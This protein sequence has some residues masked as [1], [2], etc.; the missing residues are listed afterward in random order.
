MSKKILGLDLGTNSIGWA[1]VDATFKIEN[2][3]QIVTSYNYIDDCGVRIFP[4]GVNDIGKGES[5]K[6]NNA[7]RT[8]NRQKRRHFYRKRLRKIKLLKVLI[9]QGMCPLKLEELNSWKNWDRV[10][11]SE[12]KKFPESPEFV[13]WIQ[14][15]PYKLRSKAIRGHLSL[16]ELG[17]VFYHLIQ[18]R[19][20]LSSRKGNDDP[21]TLYEKGKPEENILPINATKDKIKDSSL[22]YYLNSIVPQEGMPYK[23]IT[24]EEGNLIRAR[25]RYTTRDMYIAEFEVIW[26]KQAIHLGL[27]NRIAEVKRTRE[28]K[29]A[30]TS[31]RNQSRIEHLINIYGKDNV[32]IQPQKKGKTRV[33]TQ[34]SI[35]LKKYL[36]GNIVEVVME[37]GEK[38]LRFNSNE[39]VLFWQRPLRSQKSLI[40]NCRFENK[41][42]VINEEDS[43]VYDDKG[44]QQF[45][46]KKPCPVSHP[47]FEL[48]RAFQFINNIRYG[49]NL[50]LTIEQKQQVL[51]L[52][53]KN[54]KNFNFSDIPKLLKLTY[55][56]FNYEDDFKVPGNTTIK[57]IKSLFK[58]DVWDKHMVDIWHCFYFYDDNEKLYG[59]LKQDYGYLE[60]LETI[61]KIKLKEGYGNVSLKAIRNIQYFLEKGFQYDRAVILGGIR[62]AFG[63]R[64]SHFEES[65]NELIRDINRILNADNKEGEAIDKVKSYLANPDNHYGFVV[66]DP[67]FTHLYHHSQEVEKADELMLWVPELENLRNP[68]VQQALHETRRLVNA[69]LK[70][71]RKELGEDFEFAQIKVEMGR[72][73]RNNKLQRAKMTKDISANE[74]KNNEAR[75]RLAEYGLRPS[76]DN[77]QKYLMY[78]E[79]VDRSGKCTCPYTGKVI[80]IND[81]LG[82][83]NAIQIEHIIPY[84]ISLDD[85][86]GNKTLCEAHF[87]NAKGEKTPYEF[88]SENPDPKLWGANNWED[89][90]ERAFSILP[91]PKAKRFTSKKKFEKETF[92]QRQLN[93]SRYI[94]KKSVELLSHICHDVRVMPGQLTA[95]LRHLWG[96]N[97]IL[98]PTQKLGKHTFDIDTDKPTPYYVVTNE[99]GETIAL[100]KKFNDR[101]V[102]KS[103]ELLLT[104]N[105]SK[106]K[107]DAKHFKIDLKDIDV[108]DGHY[109]A[110]LQVN[111]SLQLKPQFADKPQIGEQH[112]VLRGKV[113]K[114]VFKNDTSGNYKIPGISDGSYWAKF[115]ISSKKFEAPE[116]DKQPKTK[117]NQL[118]LFGTVLNG[119]FNCYIYTCK[120]NLPD[121]KYWLIIDIAPNAIEFI[122][123]NNPRPEIETNE[124]CISATVDEQGYMVADCDPEY[125]QATDRM[126]GKYYATLSIESKSPELFTVEKEL[127]KVE[128][129]QK[130]VEGS[131]WVDKYTGEIKFDPK[132]NRDDHR[133]HAIDAITIALTEQGYLQR[134]STENAKRKDKQR[135]IENSTEKF[136]EPWIG[137]NNDVLEKANGLLIS[138]KQ[139]NKTLT[140][141][142]KGFSVRGQLHKENVFGV[143]QSPN[144]DKAY[145]RR[146][147]VTELK[148]NKHIGKIADITIQNHIK[149]FLRDKH[150]IDTANPKGYSIPKDAFIKDGEWQLFLP[151][152]NGGNDVPIKKVR[153]REVLSNANRLKGELN[154]HVNPRNNHHVLIYKDNEGNLQEEVVQFWTVVERKLQNMPTYLLP[155]DGVEIIAT[156]ETNDMFLLG[157]SD[158]EFN[159]NKEDSIFLSK[160]LYRVQKISTMYYT[161]RFH[162][163]STILNES[164]EWRMQ[165]FKAWEQ[166]N[167]IKVTI[168]PLGH[169]E[170]INR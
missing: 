77:I 81:L 118:L 85:S 116:K 56:K 82:A 9:E 150:G 115:E 106:N 80:S 65:E 10:E 95:E 157:L 100:Q 98:Q 58:S 134:L 125:K 137:F 59:K 153:I 4:A 163:A 27:D 34:T 25:G 40:A 70:R 152:R 103:S 132:K 166:A 7:T 68:I 170:R 113:E 41:L 53:N 92:I 108:T 78:K 75:T 159:S 38:T 99:E 139:N 169:I 112:I 127:P 52:I 141:N 51:Q 28:L 72:E 49:K 3:R 15:D 1:V 110:K 57:Q 146:T 71:Y 117:R 140:K 16:H 96:L 114:E 154:Q 133:H 135:G 13:K 168:D 31:N 83:S 93:D 69:L 84:S 73:L 105:V 29:G 48:F 121:G 97:S 45:R 26:N 18:R 55:E 155:E 17:R 39:S 101:P 23:N 79:I 131:I 44:K 47:E 63:K 124:V 88:Y 50:E 36:A 107:F 102:T 161:F 35:P 130:L 144:M 145:H 104:G 109:W 148:N 76:R 32:L 122:R 74:T 167:P 30:L 156:L 160:H 164:E 37:N 60:D 12:G 62:N 46:S 149:D 64:W 158:E 24:D 87:N 123:V 20:F 151:N 43:F 19:G 143:R 94:A 126:P 89:I 11:K 129:N 91:Y 6:S 165:S 54:D 42:P 14:L 33:I 66:N 90:A 22:G 120:T 61:K 147:K 86:F 8:E 21:K 67:H 162:L 5:E 119:K 136:P 138:F 142:K 128:K 2:G 111:G